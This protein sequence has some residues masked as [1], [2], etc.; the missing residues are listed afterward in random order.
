MPKPQC[1][2]PARAPGCSNSGLDPLPTPT[3]H[4]RPLF[5][6]IYVVLC[7]RLGKL[8]SNRWDW[9]P[10]A[11]AMPTRRN[12]VLTSDQLQNVSL[13]G[14]VHW[15]MYYFS[16]ETRTLTTSTLT[17]SYIRRDFT[18]LVCQKSVSILGRASALCSSCLTLS[19]S[20]CHWIGH[21]LPLGPL[22][23]QIQKFSWICRPLI[24]VTRTR[25]CNTSMS[26]SHF[27]FRLGQGNAPSV[28]ALG[29]PA[30]L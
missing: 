12:P 3:P 7:V 1:T 25:R 13:L 9:K 11:S 30:P 8:F 20:S 6:Q 2:I 4:L 28:C 16:E 10:W 15:T 18:T 27:N 14:S 26:K 5:V 23:A 24:P 19:I 22:P 21:H 29:H 17:Y